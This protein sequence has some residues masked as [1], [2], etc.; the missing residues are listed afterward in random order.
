MEGWENM[1]FINEVKENL[2]ENIIPFWEKLR[3][4]EHG[5]YYGLLDFDLN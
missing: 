5:G 3:D 1:S 4:N 2:T